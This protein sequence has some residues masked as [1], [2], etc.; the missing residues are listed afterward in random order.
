MGSN[1]CLGFRPWLAALKS[2][3]AA[4][5]RAWLSQEFTSPAISLNG[6]LDASGAK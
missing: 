5:T 6:W 1:A 3:H 4:V 2:E